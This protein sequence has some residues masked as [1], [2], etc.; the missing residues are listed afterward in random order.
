MTFKNAAAAKSFK[1]E[2]KEP[3]EVRSATVRDADGGSAEAGATPAEANNGWSVASDKA[4]S[5]VTLEVCPSVEKKGRK[6][7]PEAR[8]TKWK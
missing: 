7:A 4:F 6:D 5:E 3:V 8:G 2:F 1:A